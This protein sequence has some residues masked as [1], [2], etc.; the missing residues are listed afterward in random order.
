VGLAKLQ[1]DTTVSGP[2][3]PIYITSIETIFD[4][5]QR[6]GVIPVETPTVA[7]A[8]TD[9]KS[10]STKSI[11]G[12]SKHKKKVET[13]ITEIPIKAITVAFL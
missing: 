7:N 3:R 11:F 4:P 2:R 8:L 10:K 6:F 5:V 12:S 13:A 9:S 1:R